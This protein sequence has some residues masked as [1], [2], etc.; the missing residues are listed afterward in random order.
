LKEEIEKLALAIKES[1]VDLDIFDTRVDRVFDPSPPYL[2]LVAQ[3]A[4]AS[5]HKC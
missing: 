3:L 2:D 5:V 4:G 1:K